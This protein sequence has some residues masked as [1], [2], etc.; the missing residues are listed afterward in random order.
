MKKRTIK[1]I[2]MVVLIAMI[3]TLALIPVINGALEPVKYDLSKDIYDDESA[4][5]T[6]DQFHLIKAGMSSASS[7]NMQP[8]LVKIVDESTFEVY[9]DQSKLLPVVDPNNYQTLMSIGGFLA[10]I[11]DEASSRGMMIEISYAENID[12]ELESP[13]VATISIIQGTTMNPTDIRSGSTYQNDGDSLNQQT[14]FNPQQEMDRFFEQGYTI[15]LIKDEQ[16]ETFK[17]FL[18]EGTTIESTD[19]AAMDELLSIFRFSRHSKNVFRYGLSLNTISRPMQF[20]IESLVGM[21]SNWESFGKSSITTFE[22]R[23]ASE[24]SYF[25]ISKE[26]PSQLDY[27]HV[28]YLSQWLSLELSY[29]NLRPAVQLIEPLHG[30][31]QVLTDAKEQLNI[32]N[33]VMLIIGV[34][35]SEPSKA[36]E[37]IRHQVMDIIL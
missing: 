14:S 10:N 7:H 26:Q 18:L 32:T 35:W 19:Q 4:Y 31:N 6:E 21:T 24:F 13:K 9:I 29:V 25:V 1:S 5:M 17:A 22:K 16:L 23:L 12:F 34:K 20:Y 36:Y 33:E 3:T 37:S 27:L 15:D 11:D 2:V 30:M 28:G 8:W